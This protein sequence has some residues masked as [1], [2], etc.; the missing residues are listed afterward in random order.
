MGLFEGLFEE[1]VLRF[2]DQ[3][4]FLDSVLEIILSLLQVST[5]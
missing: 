1:N 5:N 3:W 2:C 4:Q